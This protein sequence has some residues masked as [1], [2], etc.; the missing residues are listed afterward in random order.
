MKKAKLITGLLLLAL[1]LA[2]QANAQEPAAADKKA[3]INELLEVTDAKNSSQK[4]LDAMLLQM[5]KEM[6]RAVFGCI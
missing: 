6:P 1:T 4:I 2:T 5:E 3:L